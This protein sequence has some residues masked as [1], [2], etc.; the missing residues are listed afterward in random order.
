MKV[1]IAGTG[2]MGTQIV[3]RLLDIGYGVFVYNRN[4][5]KTRS[6]LKKGGIWV[7]SPRDLG[8]KCQFLMLCV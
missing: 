7:A 6:L 5:R 4:K 1:G 8:N 3:E 2:L